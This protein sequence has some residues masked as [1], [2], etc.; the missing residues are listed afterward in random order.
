MLYLSRAGEHGIGMYGKLHL[1]HFHQS[2]EDV[3]D[4]RAEILH[5]HAA[6]LQGLTKDVLELFV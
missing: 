3:D 2:V 4:S 6:E 1:L 5:V